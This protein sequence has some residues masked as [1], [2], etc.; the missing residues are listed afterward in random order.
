MDNMTGAEKGKKRSE[1]R[2]LHFLLHLS[3]YFRFTG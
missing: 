1:I 2:Y 3:S